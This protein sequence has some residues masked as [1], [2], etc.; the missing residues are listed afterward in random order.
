MRV[1]FELGCCRYAFIFYFFF[2]SFVIFSIF[3]AP[4]ALLEMAFPTEA[5]YDKETRIVFELC[6]R[7]VHGYYTEGYP[8]Q[9]NSR[10]LCGI[11]E[12]P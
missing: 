1:S 11:V 2:A 9:G 4:I 3:F 5:F 6:A 12:E 10:C 7:A 8:C